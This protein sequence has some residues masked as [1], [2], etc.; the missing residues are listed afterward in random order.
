MVIDGAMGTTVQQY[1]F[2]EE[3]FLGASSWLRGRVR[4]RVSL[5]PA[6]PYIRVR[7]RVKVWAGARIG[8]WEG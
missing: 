6:V 3:D 4:V 1:K 7:V 5:A 2:S 8:V